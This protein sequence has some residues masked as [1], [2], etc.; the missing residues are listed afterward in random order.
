MKVVETW[1]RLIDYLDRL[2]APRIVRFPKSGTEGEYFFVEKPLPEAYIQF[3]NHYGYPTLFID[4]DIC[5][6]FLS[7]QQIRRHPLFPLG[8]YPFAVCSPDCQVSVAFLPQ[9][10]SIVVMAYDGMERIDI[11]GCFTEWIENQV[12]QFLLQ[13]MHYS[14]Q[15]LQGRQFL[16]GKDPLSLCSSNC[17]AKI[18]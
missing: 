13:L 5:I 2:G 3:V 6:G 14:P 11:E 4:E 1:N 10:D 12:R 15:V 8:V 9:E 17:F 18:S 16:L 7:P